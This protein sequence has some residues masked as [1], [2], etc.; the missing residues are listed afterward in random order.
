MKLRF[1]F[2]IIN[3]SLLFALLVFEP[4]RCGGRLP[5]VPAAQFPPAII[6]VEGKSTQGFSYLSGGVSSDERDAMEE[7][8]KTYNLKLVFA[9]K[10][11]AYLADVKLVIADA[12]GKEI[13]S[14]TTNGP[15]FYAQLPSANYS[16]AATLN[17]QT[18]MIRSLDLAKGKF[19]QQA[20]LW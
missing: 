7:R 5:E 13:I 9:E 4:L 18:K 8:G 14:I 15:W 20:L 11:G 12:Q 16:I 2:T 10:S 19:V 17:G 6:I 1:V 3:F